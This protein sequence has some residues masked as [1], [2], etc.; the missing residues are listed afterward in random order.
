MSMYKTIPIDGKNSKA[1]PRKTG[2]YI[3]LLFYDCVADVKW[4]NQSNVTM[5]VNSV[6]NMTQD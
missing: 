5:Y 4:C 3:A 6:F 1:L 2:I